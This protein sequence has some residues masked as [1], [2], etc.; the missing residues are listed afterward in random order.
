MR[1]GSS[2][3]GKRS[4]YTAWGFSLISQLTFTCSNSRTKTLEKGVKYV[5]LAA[6]TPEQHH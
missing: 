6:K 4:D 3:C 5:K 2:P 1:H